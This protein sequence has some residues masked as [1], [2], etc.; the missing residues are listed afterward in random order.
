M[1]GQVG[2]HVQNC[3]HCT[4]AKAPTPTVCPPMRH[5]LAFKPLERVAI[6]F[7]KFD[8]GRGNFEDVL[9]IMDSFTKFAVA[10]ILN[11]RKNL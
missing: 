1:N 11:L 10:V 6:D 4:A 7:L 5:L 8:R 3:F 2:E 9:V